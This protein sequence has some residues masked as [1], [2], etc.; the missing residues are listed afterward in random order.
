MISYIENKDD[1][2]LRI[3]INFQLKCIV[4]TFNATV[5]GNVVNGNK[6]KK[7]KIKIKNRKK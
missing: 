3:L 6:N 4:K 5:N 1:T 2:D 7:W